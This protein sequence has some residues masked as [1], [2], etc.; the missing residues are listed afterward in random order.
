V[1]RESD[2]L[3]LVPRVVV[4]DELKSKVLV[5]VFR[6]PGLREAFYAITPTRRYPNRFVQR[7]LE[8]KG[9]SR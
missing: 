6:V 5:E 3:A 1:A 7:L 4:A 9:R 2:A 8:E